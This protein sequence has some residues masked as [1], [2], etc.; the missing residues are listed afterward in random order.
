MNINGLRKA[1][2]NRAKDVTIEPV[3]TDT[4]AYFKV[5]PSGIPR[6]D[7]DH[8]FSQQLPDHWRAMKISDQTW[9]VYE[10]FG[11]VDDALTKRDLLGENDDGSI[12]TLIVQPDERCGEVE[13]IEN[14]EQV[15]VTYDTC[16]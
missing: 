11:T 14:G 16:L 9:A 5:M 15:E 8:V 2:A 4:A 3:K 6:A 1:I 13:V 12:T 7:L 10:Q